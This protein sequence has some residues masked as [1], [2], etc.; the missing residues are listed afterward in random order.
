MLPIQCQSLNVSVEAVD[1]QKVNVLVSPNIMKIVP[2]IKWVTFDFLVTSLICLLEDF[3]HS[4]TV[5]TQMHSRDGGKANLTGMYSSC[6]APHFSD[7]NI[8]GVESICWS[9]GLKLNRT[10]HMNAS[11]WATTK[12]KM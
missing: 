6:V 11:I 10:L 7:H 12:A 2:R 4:S 9:R 1:I 5:T 8:I 3:E